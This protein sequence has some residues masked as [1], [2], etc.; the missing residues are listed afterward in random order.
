VPAIN[1]S[2]FPTPG[3]TYV[4]DY[5]YQVT[6]SRTKFNHAT[7]ELNAGEPFRPGNDPRLLAEANKWRN[8]GPAYNG[9][10]LKR[11]LILEGVIAV[12]IIILASFKTRNKKNK[13]NEK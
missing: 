11:R 13:Q 1:F 5:R 6:N 4:F 2:D 9:Y 7:Y 3:K 12:I 8:H 10:E